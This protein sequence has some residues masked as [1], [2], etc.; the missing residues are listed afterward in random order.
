MTTRFNPERHHRRSIRLQEHDY[1]RACAYFVTICTQDR[2]CLFGEVIDRALRL[3]QAGVAVQTVWNDIPNHYAG[4]DIDAFVVMPNHIHGIIVLTGAAV[5]GAGPR[6]CQAPV[7]APMRMPMP[8]GGNHGGLPL[9]YPRCR[10]G[11]WCIGS[12]R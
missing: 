6:A 9:R 10:W 12:K 8:I 4:V 11:M 1:T 5:V 2:A 3:N 7:P